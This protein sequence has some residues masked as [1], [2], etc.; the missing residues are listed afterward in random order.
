MY[1]WPLGWIGKVLQDGIGATFEGVSATRKNHKTTQ[2]KLLA[3]PL[4]L[5]IRRPTED[6]PCHIEDCCPAEVLG[7]VTG[8]AEYDQRSQARSIHCKFKFKLES[9]L[10][11]ESRP[12]NPFNFV[13]SRGGAHAPQAPVIAGKAEAWKTPADD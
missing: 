11:K 10:V 1:R 8:E 3:L 6:L 9:Y 13:L 7:D 12:A 5:L 4:I 2:T